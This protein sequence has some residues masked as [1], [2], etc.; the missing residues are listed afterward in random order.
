ML[1]RH[2]HSTLA[3]EGDTLPD[4]PPELAR[5]P[6]ETALAFEAFLTYLRLGPR[7]SIRQVAALN[8]H[9][10]R[11]LEQVSSRNKW[12]ARCRQFDEFVARRKL[13]SIIEEATKGQGA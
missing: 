12:A 6:R 1:D 4:L 8:G 2:T 11:W 13:A 7:R 9:D 3:S 5:L 10:E